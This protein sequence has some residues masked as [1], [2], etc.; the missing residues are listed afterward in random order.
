VSDIKVGDRVRVVM[1]ER[2]KSYETYPWLIDATGTVTEIADEYVI[3]REWAR[4]HGMADDEGGLWVA[5]DDTDQ[6][7]ALATG[8]VEVL[9]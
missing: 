2:V 3:D 7:A 9:A 1:S 4:D 6:E 5:L 8:D